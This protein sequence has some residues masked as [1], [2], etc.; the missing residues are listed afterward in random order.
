[1]R[2]SKGIGI[3]NVPNLTL[4]FIYILRLDKPVCLKFFVLFIL[5]EGHVVRWYPSR[6]CIKATNFERAL[7]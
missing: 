3:E 4:I 5:C 7:P 1:M 6:N 2:R